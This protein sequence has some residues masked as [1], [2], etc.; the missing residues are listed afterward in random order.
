[1]LSLLTFFS[2]FKE[3]LLGVATFPEVLNNLSDAAIFVHIQRYLFAI[4]KAMGYYCADSFTSPVG[5]S[6]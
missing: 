4:L 2:G 1:L 6:F 3:L 5:L